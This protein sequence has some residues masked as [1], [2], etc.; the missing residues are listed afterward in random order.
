M[1]KLALWYTAGSGLDLHTY[2]VVM[3]LL[4]LSSQP[5]DIEIS[6]DL[7]NQ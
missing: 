2:F 4:F 6:L 5:L 1:V 7:D 3:R